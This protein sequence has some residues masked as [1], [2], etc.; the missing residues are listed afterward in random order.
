VNPRT[1]LS[2]PL[3]R[4]HRWNTLLLLTGVLYGLFVLVPSGGGFE[5]KW[6]SSA[7]FLLIALFAA[8]NVW[9]VARQH[10]GQKREGWLLIALGLAMVVTAYFIWGYLTVTTEGVPFP[11]LADLFWFLFIPL[12]MSGILRMPRDPFRPF[13][14][15]KLALDIVIMMAVAAHFLWYVLIASTIPGYGTQV[16]S[17]IVGITYPLLDLFLV[18]TLLVMVFRDYGG[19]PLG[20]GIRWFVVA[21]CAQVSADLIYNALTSRGRYF[22]GH[23]VDML[24]I[25]AYLGYSLAASASLASTTHRPHPVWT[26]IALFFNRYGAYLGSGILA[27]LFAAVLYGAQDTLAAKGI[28]FAAPIMVLLLLVRQLFALLENQRLTNQVSSV[29]TQLQS[30]VRALAGANAGLRELSETLEQKVA[31]RTQELETSQTRLVAAEK[32]ASMGRLT[33][34]LAHEINTPLA[35]ARNRLLA[36]RDLAEEYRQA[37]GDKTVADDDHREIAG[38]L[39]QLLTEADHRLE[40]L[41]EFVRKIRGHTRVAS[42]GTGKFDPLQVTEDTL[43]M[44]AP[45]ARS[46]G[47]TLRF[48]PPRDR[49][50]LLGEPGR[51]SQVVTNLVLNAVDACE[52]ARDEALV[53]V[54]LQQDAGK[55]RLLV[56]DNGGGIAPEVLPKIFDPMFTTKEVGKGT[57][58]G[59]S[60]TYDIVKGHFGGE[61][62]VQSQVGQG[63]VFAVQLPLSSESVAPLELATS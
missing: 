12:V 11:S 43:A 63:S 26:Q 6:L 28:I 57:G 10:Q 7:L 61:I 32:L 18:A 49:L 38:E 4:H 55:L 53:V 8:L 2:P 14:N 37:I 13:E 33:A 34:G 23:W 42:S 46:A 44:L 17:L 27:L 59:L 22:P 1:A 48:D 25:F 15:L 41:G 58:L 54:T 3:R 29:N 31:L 9:Q 20:A 45:Q 19:S 39:S 56:E 5:R 30:H 51:F 21:L 36:A 24:W 62:S 52:N 40:Q 60:I 35:S 16:L 50:T 47:V